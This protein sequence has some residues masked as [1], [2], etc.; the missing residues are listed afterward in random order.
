MRTYE[1]RL[2]FR[3]SLGNSTAAASFVIATALTFWTVL[4]LRPAAAAS[5]ER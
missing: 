5:R 1:R 2:G 4:A 3:P